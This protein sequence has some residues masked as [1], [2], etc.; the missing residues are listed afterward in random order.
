LP[1][2]GIRVTS[3]E[4]TRNRRSRLGAVLLALRHRPMAILRRTLLFVVAALAGS[5]P[6]VASASRPPS[7]APAEDPPPLSCIVDEPVDPLGP[8]FLL[9]RGRFT[10]IDVPDAVLETA[11]FG[12]S[13]RGQIV[14]GYDSAGFAVHGFRLDRGRYTTIDYP[15][16]SR[17]L[18]LRINARGQV[19]GLYEDARGGCHG[20]L[21][22]RG[23][24]KTID[25]PGA[26]TQALGLNDPGDIVGTYADFDAGRARG[27]LRTKGAYSPIDFPGAQATNAYDINA[28]GQIVGIY[29]DAGGTMGTCGDGTA[30][31]PGSTFPAPR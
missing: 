25:V 28:G 19:L 15:G 9:D 1:F 26:P 16:A 12:I 30:T 13:N 8:G 22:E 5:T 29:A 18:A 14:G 17:T 20:Y 11:P 4:T 3:L 2:E 23:A 27:F 10:T 31:T 21:L 24:F 7:D 6:A